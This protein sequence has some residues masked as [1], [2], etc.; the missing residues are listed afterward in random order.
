MYMDPSL[1]HRARAESLLANDFALRSADTSRSGRPSRF[2]EESR[3]GSEKGP[4]SQ[5]FNTGKTTDRSIKRF[6]LFFR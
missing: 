5:Y 4:N 1:L 2:L 3:L 6:L